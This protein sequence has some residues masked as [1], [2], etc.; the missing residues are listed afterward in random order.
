MASIIKVDQIQESTTGVGTNFSTTGSATTPTIS[1]GNQTNKG[2]YH[3]GND[4]IGVS[5][6]GSK[7]GEI[8]NNYGGFLNNI[9]N[10]V[11]VIGTT[12]Y[13]GITGTIS[14]ITTTYTPKFS[15]SLLLIQSEI[16]WLSTA[17]SS[18]P[19]LGIGFYI[20]GTHQRWYYYYTDRSGTI[21]DSTIQTLPYTVT[22]T[23]P[24][25]IRTDWT[26]ASGSPSITIYGST[27][28]YNH[29]LRIWEI[30]R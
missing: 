6:G 19:G 18:I 14:D 30:M 7:V 17:S 29:Y 20:N 24:I 12:D 26:G 13:S 16:S 15:N 27:A 23:S 22:S 11:N 4:K 9:C 8:G 10:F 5:I 28:N 21:V 2:F 1:L 25:T 3:V